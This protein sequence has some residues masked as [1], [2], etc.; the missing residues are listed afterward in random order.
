MQ[1]TGV[2]AAKKN[3]QDFRFVTD[4]LHSGKKQLS[5]HKRRNDAN[6]GSSPFQLKRLKVLLYV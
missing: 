5:K 2:T 3:K 6:E 4:H 1:L